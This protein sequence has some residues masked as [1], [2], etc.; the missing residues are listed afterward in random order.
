MSTAA[1]ILAEL[2]RFETVSDRT[3]LPLLDW[4]EAYLAEWGV[5]GRRVMDASGEKANLIVTIGPADVPGYVLSGHV[6]V[7][8]VE[9]QDWTV[10]PFGG[11]IRDGRVWGRGASDMKGFV[12]VVLAAVPDMVAAPLARP[13]HIVLSYDEEIGCV[14]VRSAVR[15]LS[16]WPVRPL[17]CFVGEPTGMDV[18]LGHKAKVAT[19]AVVTGRAGHSSRAPE[20]VNA[21]EYAARLAVWISDRG[22]ALADNGARDPAYDIG[23]T[24]AHVGVLAGG[25]QLNLVPERAVLDFEFRAIAADDPHDLTAEA[26]AFAEGTLAPAMR[27]VTTEAGIAF[28]TLSEAPGLDTPPETGIVTYAKSLAG[29]NGHRKVAFGTEAGLFAEAGIPSV[30]IGPGDIARA[31]KADEYV[32]IA[33]L[34]ACGRFLSRLV[35]DS[36][37]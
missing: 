7:V 2:I 30:V 8:P 3:N 26:V 27:R 34:E 28:E 22:R 9:G 23:H 1:K 37:V 36:R 6:D 12:A 24:T 5:A 16:T 14:G 18:V 15:E 33:E 10:P 35:A 29:R 20:A 4:V 13:L 31:H 19:R 25:V 11:V 17:G 32:E 21:A